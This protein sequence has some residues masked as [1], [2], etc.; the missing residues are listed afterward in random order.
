MKLKF[1]ADSKDISLFL[2]FAIVLLYLVA[3]AILNLEQF[4]SD[5]TF[6]GLNPIKAFT[7]DY[8]W[9]TFVFYIFSLAL[10]MIQASSLFFDRETGLGFS[11]GKKDKGGY[12]R[13]AKE[14]EMKKELKR[15]LPSDESS[16]AA[17]MPLINNGKELWV[18]DGEYHNLVIGSTGSG[19]TQIVVLPLVKILAK[20]GESMIITDPKGEIYRENADM[21]RKK[22]YSVIVLN[23]RDPQLGSAW[24]PLML[25]YQLYKDGNQDKAIELLDDLAINILYDE[26][27]QAQDPFWEK[28]SA[29]YFVG[30]ALALFE[31]A[32]EE[33][34]NLNSINL[35]STV[36]EERF[37]GSTY[38]K[39]YFSE[40]DPG[41]PMCIN[42]SSTM[43]APSDTKTSI[44]AVF[45]QK[46]KLFS[47]SVKISEMLSHNDIDMKSIGRQKTAVFLVIQDEKRTYHPLVTTFIKQCYESLIDVAQENGDGKLKYRTNFI[48][49]EFANMPP[50]KDVTTMITAARS[51]L[52]RMTLIIQNFAQLYQVYGKENGETIKGNCGNIV[53][54]ISS[55]LSALEEISKL[56]GESKSKE[57]DKTASTPL[58]TISDLQRLKKGETIILRARKMPFKTKMTYNY[59][60]NWGKKYAPSDFI[61]RNTLTV[62]TFNIKEF[63][64]AKDNKQGSNIFGRPAIGTAPNMNQGLMGFRDMESSIG[65]EDMMKRID[66]RIAEMDANES[67]EEEVEK[68]KF[69]LPDFKSTLE[70]AKE[71]FLEQPAKPEPI[72]MASAPV[73]E[74]PAEEEI[75]GTPI[76][77]IAPTKLSRFIPVDLPKEVEKPRVVVKPIKRGP[78][79]TEVLVNHVENSNENT[80]IIED[81]VIPEKQVGISDDQ[82]FDDFFSDDDE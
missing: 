19:K 52:I 64:E 43:T 54:L 4:A 78:I 21:L 73:V 37:N 49:D 47:S 75:I 56:A 51:R 68:P 39:Q 12:S 79:D 13:W 63:M 53:Y 11:F 28:T 27:G 58:I 18:D 2:V 24:N 36:G 20:K 31:D 81:R 69:E 57:K 7:G 50:L 16:S 62:K 66:A 44:L 61:S 6:H 34:I 32:K 30:L 46:I 17:G 9:P 23:F 35:M 60:M 48:L 5:S 55:E 29:D 82:F 59:Q 72:V 38:L 3:I 42:V 45:K 41:S 1:R 65:I 14:S 33:E 76:S 70:P 77:E 40:K 22:G 25:P 15:V 26:K 8:I 67:A 74:T 10:I 80:P 71:Y